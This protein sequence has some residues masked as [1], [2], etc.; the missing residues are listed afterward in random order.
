LPIA[1]RF[2]WVSVCCLHRGTGVLDC[3][4][5]ARITLNLAARRSSTSSTNVRRSS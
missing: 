2:S 5:S 3:A 4:R 1:N